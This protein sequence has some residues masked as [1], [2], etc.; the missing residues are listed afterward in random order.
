M[1]RR[2]LSIV[3]AHCSSVGT[4]GMK[5]PAHRPI[6]VGGLFEA[7]YSNILA[8]QRD[9]GYDE[10]KPQMLEAQGGQAQM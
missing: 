7:L 6:V 9:L 10:E 8:S 2:V 3:M 4:S 5:M 1:P